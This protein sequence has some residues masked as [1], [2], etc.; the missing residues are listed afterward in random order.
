MVKYGGKVC[1]GDGEEIRVCNNDV[2]CL[3]RLDFFRY[4]VNVIEFYLKSD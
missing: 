1:K 4:I 3:G 2:L